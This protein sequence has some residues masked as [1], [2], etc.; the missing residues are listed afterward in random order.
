MLT[1]LKK[2]NETPRIADFGL[3]RM[4]AV[5]NRRDADQLTEGWDFLTID[6]RWKKNV[7]SPWTMLN[8]HEFH[9]DLRILTEFREKRSCRNLWFLKFSV[10]VPC[11]FPE[12]VLDLFGLPFSELPEDDILIGNILM[13]WIFKKH[14]VLET[15]KNRIKSTRYS[16]GQRRLKVGP[17]PGNTVLRL[18]CRIFHGM[19][20]PT[21]WFRGGQSL[22][23]TKSFLL[24]LLVW[25]C[26]EHLL[27]LS[28][29]IG[30][31]II[32]T[33]WNR[34]VGMPPTR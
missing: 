18:T 12:R 22:E 9:G 24:W 34:R 10:F 16:V 31:F 26:L 6:L 29:S 11:R 2:K 4:M 19:W 15:R 13:S 17:R 30:N 7:I 33:D 14:E 1:G 21:W 20:H 25:K 3:A 23:W 32:P 5:P 28:I 8:L 27:W